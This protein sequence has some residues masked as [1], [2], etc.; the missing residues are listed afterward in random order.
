MFLCHYALAVL[1]TLFIRCNSA[2]TELS[3]QTLS[4]ASIVTDDL[5]AF[6]GNILSP[7]LQPRV[8]GSK[9]SLAVRRHIVKFFREQLPSWDVELQESSSL[10]PSP[11]LSA[12]GPRVVSFVNIIATRDPRPATIRTTNRLVI[13]AHYDSKLGDGRIG[14]NGEALFEDFVGATDSAAPCAIMLHAA[15]TVDKLLTKKWDEMQELGFSF[16]M[17]RGI[18]LVFF[19][20]E[21]AFGNWSKT[22]SLYGSRALAA[23]WSLEDESGHRDIDDIELLLLLDLLGASEV[24]VPSFFRDTHWAY[25]QLAKI[26][27]DF[28]AAGLLES[29]R[30]GYDAT[31]KPAIY[32]PDAERNTEDNGAWPG[33]TLGD[34]H[35]PFW[36]LGARVLHL[37]SVPYPTVWHSMR[38]DAAH[39]DMPKVRDWTRLISA[40]ICGWMHLD[41]YT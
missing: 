21:E 3:G 4:Y 13:A 7:I 19:D 17:E 9:G 39:L 35:I 16:D 2:F 36:Q 40:F 28:R 33:G 22:D 31:S 15:R 12:T 41:G 29:T 37:I 6:Q 34:D 38:D 18:R 8:P 10:V 14:E 20:G 23:H 1:A 27:Q 32:F 26:E 5:D 25:Q 30:L 11:V 24:S